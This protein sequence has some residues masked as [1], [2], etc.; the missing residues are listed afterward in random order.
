VYLLDE[1]GRPVPDGE[2]GEIYIGGT[3]VARGYRNRPELTWERFLKN[4]FS[5]AVDARM[6]RT[7]DLGCLL[8]DG[9]ISFRGRVDRQEKIR[10]YRI[11]PDEIVNNLN[12]HPDVATSAVAADGATPHEKR[13]VAYVVPVSGA[14]PS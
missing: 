3:S 14:S 8:P 1:H 7:G 9:Q 11:E 5:P 4:P 2:T 13:L 12:L 10:G 6:Y